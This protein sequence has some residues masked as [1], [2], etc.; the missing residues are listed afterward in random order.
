LLSS[1]N[2]HLSNPKQ[3]KRTHLQGR[4]K[5]TLAHRKQSFSHGGAVHKRVTMYVRTWYMAKRPEKRGTNEPLSEQGL[6]TRFS[7]TY[8]SVAR[9][10]RAAYQLLS[11]SGF[12]LIAALYCCKVRTAN[13]HGYLEPNERMPF[14]A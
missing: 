8:R 12:F 7:S 3:L 1:R 6:V 5:L 9:F 14:Q 10:L 4:M 13:F 11:S 2:G